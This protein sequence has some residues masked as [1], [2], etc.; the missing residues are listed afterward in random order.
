MKFEINSRRINS[1]A[2]IEAFGLVSTKKQKQKRLTIK[3]NEMVLQEMEKS[4]FR[5]INILFQ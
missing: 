3:N 1:I 5:Q 2:E 4:K